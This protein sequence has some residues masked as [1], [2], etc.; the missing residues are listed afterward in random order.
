VADQ[1]DSAKIKERA[2]FLQEIAVELLKTVFSDGTIILRLPR[3]KLVAK[4]YFILNACYKNWRIEEGHYTEEPKIAALQCMSIATFE[5][6][7]PV[8]T[9]NAQTVAEA[10]SNEIYA[11]A[12]AAA[13]LEIQID[14]HVKREFYLRLLDVLS[15]C[16][17]ETLEPYVVD[18]DL[19]INRPLKGY[20]GAVHDND[21]FGL[22][23][24]ITIFE[25]FGHHFKP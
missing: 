15:S 10:R 5:P 18:V 1:F 22:D 13:I 11:I 23:S 16:R 8:N 25:L 6:F 7:R 3:I 20:V 2:A 14:A 17:S 24:L 12:C 9:T 21:K 19:Q 4:G